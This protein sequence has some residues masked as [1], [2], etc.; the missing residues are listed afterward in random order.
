MKNELIKREIEE[1]YKDVRIGKNKKKLS[2]AKIFMELLIDREINSIAQNT[3]Y[4]PELCKVKFLKGGKEFQKKMDDEVK[5][6]IWSSYINLILENLCDH[7]SLSEIK[8]VI[9]NVDKKK[10]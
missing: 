10:F 7:S 6:G 4:D 3:I 5:F 1:V 2:K 9:R 8:K